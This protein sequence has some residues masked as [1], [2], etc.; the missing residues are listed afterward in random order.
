MIRRP[1]A[2]QPASG[3]IARMALVSVLAA[4]F[5]TARPAAA[6][7]TAVN[8]IEPNITQLLWA[9]LTRP[10]NFNRDQKLIVQFLYKDYRSAIS[11]IIEKTDDKA[12]QAGRSQIQQ[13][14]AGRSRLSPQELRDL[15]A[16]VLGVYR[17]CWPQVDE[18]T[19]NLLL[20][21]EAVLL[22]DQ[23]PIF[24]RGMMELRRAVWLQPRQRAERTYDYAGDG[25]DM[26]ALLDE[27]TSEHGMLAGLDT[28]QF[29]REIERYTQQLDA[30]LRDSGAAMREARL[31]MRIARTLR[32]TQRQADAA[33]TAMELWRQ[34]YELNGT[35]ATTIARQAAEQIGPDV[36]DAWNQTYLSACF[37]WLFEDRRPDRQYRWLNRKQLTANQRQLIETTYEK[38][39]QRFHTLAREAVDL[40]IQSRIQHAMPLHAMI[41]PTQ[42][43]TSATRELYEQLLKNSGQMSALEDATS[44]AFESALDDELRRQ[45]RRA[46]R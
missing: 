25:V 32:D 41:D 2:L 34:L 15:R 35:F 29:A 31:E 42:L 12:E 36:A 23:R 4:L 19:A 1:A 26:L 33:E 11:D 46:I 30:L 20:G 13:A 3:A 27:A 28:T 37:T 16:E 38:Y 43:T 10:L 22:D 18:A 21:L 7:E 5:L 6:D 9:K 44:D 8:F 14:L 24:Q 45:F 17:N 39:N 40:M